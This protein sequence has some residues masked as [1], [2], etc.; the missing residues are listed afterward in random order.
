MP[1]L[2]DCK[3][4]HKRQIFAIEKTNVSAVVSSRGDSRKDRK[5]NP[6]DLELLRKV[7]VFVMK[8]MPNE[9]TRAIKTYELKNGI[10]S[11]L[12][13][14]RVLTATGFRMEFFILD[15][16]DTWPTCPPES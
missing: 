11:L 4:R 2:A 7:K 14:L 10:L 9:I 13:L 15:T 6:F 8:R 12:K 3:T 1:L 5:R 16:L